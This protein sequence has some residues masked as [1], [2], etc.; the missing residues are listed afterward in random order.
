MENLE[1]VKNA[2]LL[3]LVE[4]TIST[5]EVAQ[6]NFDT[7]L[8]PAQILREINLQFWGAEKLLFWRF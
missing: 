4:E 1:V 2:L 6:V 8:R 3:N 5:A 7:F